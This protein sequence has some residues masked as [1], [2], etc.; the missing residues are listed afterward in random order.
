LIVRQHLLR[1]S[2]GIGR[3]LDH[4]RRHRIDEHR[5]APRLSP[6]GGWRRGIALV[7]LRLVDLAEAAVA[8]AH[9]RASVDG[10]LA[11]KWHFPA[12]SSVGNSP[13]R[14]ASWRPQ[15]KVLFITGYV[16]NAVIGNGHLDPG[17]QIL[18]KPFS[19]ESPAQRIR[20]IV[21]S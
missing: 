17:M 12:E 19:M 13:T 20:A 11:F 16:E 4:Q 6:V 9:L 10:K 15:L 1:H 18:A 3:R 21:E 8:A 5:L 2:F 14:R 7:S